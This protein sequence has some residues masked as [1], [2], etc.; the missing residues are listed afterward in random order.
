M[1][2]YLC[3][4]NEDH[5]KVIKA[6]N[7]RLKDDTDKTI[8]YSDFIKYE[9]LIFIDRSSEGKAPEG[10]K[11]IAEIS[12]SGHDAV[13]HILRDT[14]NDEKNNLPLRHNLTL[15]EWLSYLTEGAEDVAKEVKALTENLPAKLYDCDTGRFTTDSYDTVMKAFDDEMDKI[16]D[17]LTAEQKE[18]EER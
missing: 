9:N 18:S 1:N 2:L 7:E 16:Y 5:E 11:S 15:S 6:I 13:V 17:D 14:A 3:T 12:L 10:Y 4:P 8:P